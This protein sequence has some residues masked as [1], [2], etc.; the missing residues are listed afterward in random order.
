MMILPANTMF[1]L[2]LKSFNQNPFVHFR[3]PNA[4]AKFLAVR[5]QEVCAQLRELLV[6]GW[7][8]H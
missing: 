4:R 5:K 3:N 7:H 8:W 2:V 6:S 1:L